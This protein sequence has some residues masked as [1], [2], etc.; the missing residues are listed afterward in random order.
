VSSDANNPEQQVQPFEL[1]IP[2]EKAWGLVVDQVMQLPRTKVVSQESHY[3]HVECR[4]QVF[5][6]VDDVEFHLRPESKMVAVRSAS[7]TGYSDFGVNRSRIE[8]LREALRQR[9]VVQ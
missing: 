4:S 5:G 9:G 8:K 6:F 1:K 7:R 2:A 3:L